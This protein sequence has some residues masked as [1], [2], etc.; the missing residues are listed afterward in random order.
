MYSGSLL[1][2]PKEFAIWYAEQWIGKWYKWGGDD[3]SGFDCSGFIIEVLKSV[4]GVKRSFDTTAQG[5]WELYKDNVPDRTLGPGRGHLVFWSGRGPNK[6]VHVE[7]MLNNRLAIGASGGGSKTLTVE[8]AI[9]DNAFI[10]I[11]DIYSREG[12]YGFLD[13]FY[14]MDMFTNEEFID[15]TVGRMCC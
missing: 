9:R 15:G 6:I 4:G 14:R 2:D 7:L 3:S 8:D 1:A 13:P 12:I 11:R 10:K 5:L